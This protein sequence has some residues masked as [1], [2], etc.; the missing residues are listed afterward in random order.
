MEDLFTSA[1]AESLAS[2]LHL[3]YDAKLVVFCS[4]TESMK[5]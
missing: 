4:K 2:H 3:T 1:A 5:E